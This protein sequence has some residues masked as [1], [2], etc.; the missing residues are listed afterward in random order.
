MILHIILAIVAC[1]AVGFLNVDFGNPSK[2]RPANQTFQKPTGPD[3][4]KN[5]LNDKNGWNNMNDSELDQS[6]GNRAGKEPMNN[7]LPNMVSLDGVSL[8]GMGDHDDNEESDN[9]PIQSTMN[10][11]VKNDEAT[12]MKAIPWCKTDFLTKHQCTTLNRDGELHWNSHLKLY[13]IPIDFMY[14]QKAGGEFFEVKP[15]KKT[16]Y[17]H[18]WRT[19]NREIYEE[20]RQSMLTRCPFPIETKTNFRQRLQKD[21][22]AFLAVPVRKK[23]QTRLE[24]SFPNLPPLLEIIQ[25][26]KIDMSD[27]PHDDPVLVDADSHHW[28]KI[29]SDAEF[30]PEQGI[31]K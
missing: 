21:P 20:Q 13:K 22:S 19:W 28:F 17:I 7:L 31:L 2:I 24:D 30:S 12:A 4:M 6:L 23:I 11:S 27:E 9:S 29:D 1:Q 15:E 25:W 10:E 16:V 26:R 8:D 3:N 14:E 5:L 18:F